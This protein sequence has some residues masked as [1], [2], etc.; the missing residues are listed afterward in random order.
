MSER[1][2]ELRNIV[3]MLNSK[4][5]NDIQFGWSIAK[6]LEKDIELNYVIHFINDPWKRFHLSC[7]QSPTYREIDFSQK[8][9]EGLI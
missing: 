2:Q 3:K 9:Y 4:Q 7:K 6:T 1:E 8:Q 5:E